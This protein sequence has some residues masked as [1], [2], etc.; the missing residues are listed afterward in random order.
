MILAATHVVFPIIAAVGLGFAAT[1]YIEK[2]F[3]E[4]RNLKNII[5]LEHEVE[6]NSFVSFDFSVENP[7]KIY[8]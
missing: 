3:A 1:H 8:K 2:H 7:R 5:N 4:E 6:K